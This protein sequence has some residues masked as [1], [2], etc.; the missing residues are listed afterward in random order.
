MTPPVLESCKE[1]VDIVP[2]VGSPK[3]VQGWSWFSAYSG[4][5][6]CQVQAVSGG[7]WLLSCGSSWAYSSK[8]G[9]A[10]FYKYFLFQEKGEVCWFRLVLRKQNASVSSLHWEC[11]LKLA[12]SCSEEGLSSLPPGISMPQFC[13]R[14]A[15]EILGLYTISTVIAI[16]SPVWTVWDHVSLHQD[17]GRS[18]TF[19]GRP[20]VPISLTEI[21]HVNRPCNRT[22]LSVSTGCSVTF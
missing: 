20:D 17:V 5:Q 21:L 10:D 3:S 16:K 11:W 22:C 19:T 2:L 12:T 1:H 6:W 15:E 9:E 18:W 4:S 7:G 14:A 13:S 8:Y